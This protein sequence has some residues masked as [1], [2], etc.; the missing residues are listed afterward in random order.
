[1]TSDVK[2]IDKG[3]CWMEER[4][5]IIVKKNRKKGRELNIF[6]LLM[7]ILVI[8]AVMTYIVPAGQ[9]ERE[10]VNGRNVI[11]SGSFSYIDSTPIGPIELLSSIP[12]GMV[13]SAGIIFFVLIIGGAFTVLNATGAT[14][15]LILTLTKKLGNNEKWL[16]PI[17]MLFF[18]LNGALLGAF[19]EVLP[20]VVILVPL[21][22]ALGFDAMTGIAIVFV[23]VSA[24]FTAAVMNPF[25]IGVAQRV[26]ELPLYS[27]MGL[28][29][30]VFIVMYLV[31]VFYVY[32]HAMKVKRDPSKGI[33][34]TVEPKSREELLSSSVTLTTRHKWVLATFIANLCVIAY[35]VIIQDWYFYEISGMFVLFAIVIATIGGL[36]VN[37][38]VDEFLKGAASLVPGAL[39]IG[40]A[41]S[42]VV[43]LDQGHIID[44]ILYGVSNV[45]EVLPS[46]LTAVGMLVLQTLISFVI[47]SGSG[48]AA[49][50][51]PIMAPLADLVG[52]TRQTAVLAYQFGDALTNLLVPGIAVAAISM[53]G[54]SYV[55]WV[56][57]IFPLLSIQFG[58]AV[59]VMIIAN[60]INY[61][62]F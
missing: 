2:W 5:V 43:I 45:I 18:A 34:G 15:A 20:Y 27:G 58:T 8:G 4:E 59:I 1:M 31:G 25:T 24:G 11:V 32:R 53:V 47:P 13:E 51:M 9:F 41:R 37:G 36:G 62:P 42:I 12:A 29:I 38:M 46:S 50:T 54:I 23:G 10:E 60:A 39:I 3:D 26:A 14:E 22:L 21:V 55:R 44:T 52:V 35:G 28:R 30:V 61:G 7:S 33:F 6:A 16:I 48:M 19:E 17:L 40:L 49:L 57:W 56:R